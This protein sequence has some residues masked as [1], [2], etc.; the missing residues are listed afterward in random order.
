MP[1]TRSFLAIGMMSG[2][3]MDGI[4]AAILETDGESIGRRGPFLSQS[5]DQAFRERMRSI[6][7]QES[8]AELEAVSVELTRRHAALVG[9]L[10]G[11]AGLAPGDI[12]VVGFHGHTVLHD[13]DNR[14]TLQIGD[15]DLLARE[16]GI[17]VVADFRSRDVSEGGQGAPL[18]S[19]YHRALFGGAERPVAILN[20]GG[21]ANVTWVGKGDDILA[22]DTG[23]ANAMIDDWVSRQ[24]GQAY[25]AAGALAATGQVDEDLVSA[26]LRHPYFGRRP[27]KSLDRDDFAA[28]WQ[29][30]QRG[31]ALTA[32][33]G[34]AT[35]AAFTVRSVILAREHLPQM[36][37][38]WL[39][40]GGGRH[41]RVIM[42]QLAE[43]LGVP[44]EPIEVAGAN[45]D[46]LEAEAFAFLAVRSLRGLPLSVPGTTGVPK[47]CPGGR[48]F[49]WSV[50][51]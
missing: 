39:V 37:G 16:T 1:K 41:N 20:L 14:R 10:M 29:R 2:T 50:R 7:G 26:L 35:L 21:V 33:D 44:V 4:D 40:T 30:V 27:P 8:G 32:A 42:E 22:F 48:L 13:P 17:N 34:A 47:P 49:E 23:P 24:T 19:L 43:G 9:R 12:D 51:T 28:I 38:R 6:L 45:G 15:G 18:A 31:R 11:D 3:S 25:D 36:P 46:A 5:Y